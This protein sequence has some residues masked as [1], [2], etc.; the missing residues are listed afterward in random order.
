[1]CCSLV[2]NSVIRIRHDGGGRWQAEVF[3]TTRVFDLR[4]QHAFR[5]EGVSG[6]VVVKTERRHEKR[7]KAAAIRF[8]RENRPW[9]WRRIVNAAELIHIVVVV[10]VVDSPTSNTHTRGWLGR[11]TT[12]LRARTR[13]HPIKRRRR[14]RRH[15]RRWYR[16]HGGGGSK[17]PP[18]RSD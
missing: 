9:P 11:F 7:G 13:A 17:R 12:V 4:V 14:R 2:K 1:M 3:I 6:R 5:G 8:M 18:A 10:V 16:L 15:H